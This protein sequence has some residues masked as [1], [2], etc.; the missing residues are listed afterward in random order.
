[1]TKTNGQLSTSRYGDYTCNTVFPNG[2]TISTPTYISLPMPMAKAL[3]NAV[4]ETKLKQLQELGWDDKRVT[5]SSGITVITATKPPMTPLE[6][7][8]RTDEAGIR[9]I[10]FG[11]GG[12]PETLIFKIQELTGTEV[13]TKEMVQEAQSLWVEHV[14]TDNKNADKGIKKTNPTRKRTTKTKT[15]SST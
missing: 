5:G 14:T 8:L 1:M 12:A 7:E 11:R 4:R 2:I 15:A 3:V 9:S 10:L 6:Q 13:V